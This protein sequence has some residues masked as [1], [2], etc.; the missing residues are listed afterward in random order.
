[1]PAFQSAWKKGSVSVLF[2][3]GGFVLDIFW[4]E[5]KLRKEQVFCRNAGECKFRYGNKTSTTKTK[6]SK[7]ISLNTIYN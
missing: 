5:S 3:R 7:R 2:A 6:K 4:H 1:M